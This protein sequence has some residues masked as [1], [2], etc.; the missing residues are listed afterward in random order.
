MAW[1]NITGIRA[2]SGIVVA[3]VVVIVGVGV[4][5]VVV[6]V[7]VVVRVVDNVV[8]VEAVP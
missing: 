3:L 7:I 5:V 2:V 6:V 4:V 1:F 8:V